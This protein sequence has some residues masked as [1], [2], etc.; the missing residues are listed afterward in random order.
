MRGFGTRDRRGAAG[1]SLMEIIVAVAVIA[2]LAGVLT[3][4]I[5]N[6]IEESRK[7]SAAED[8]K[9]IAN[10]IGAYRQDIGTYPPGQQNDP[11]YNYGNKA[12]FGYGAEVLNKW[13]L[14]GSKKYLSKAIGNDPWGNPYSYHI[15]TRS[16]PYMDVAVFSHGPNKNCESWNG[17]YWNQGVFAADD[18][19]A[20]YDVAK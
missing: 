6:V 2:L 4:M 10:A 15:Y 14:E 13:L 1:F 16:D 18:I 9:A 17:T 5:G 12:Y 20:F 19:G 11:T 7:A 3:P 8:C